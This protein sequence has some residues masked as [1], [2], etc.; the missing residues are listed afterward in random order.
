VIKFNWKSQKDGTPLAKVSVQ[1][2]LTRDRAANL[3]IAGARPREPKDLVNYSKAH[4]ELCIRSQLRDNAER[5]DFWGDEYA[6]EYGSELSVEQV[7][8]W[9]QRQ[10]AKL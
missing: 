7:L 10:V 6:E 9:A 8:A 2:V 5:A 4:I 3:L 1:H